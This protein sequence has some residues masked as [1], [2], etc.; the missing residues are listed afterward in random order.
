MKLEAADS[1]VVESVAEF[2]YFGSSITRDVDATKAVRR[3]GMAVSVFARLGKVR[4][5]SR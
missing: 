3:I 1:T 2:I 5:S 4:D